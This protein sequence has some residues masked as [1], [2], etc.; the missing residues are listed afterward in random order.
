MHAKCLTQPL[1][2]SKAG[3]METVRGII[4]GKFWGWPCGLANMP[5]EGCY[6]LSHRKPRTLSPGAPQALSQ[7]VMPTIPKPCCV[8]SNGK[9]IPLIPGSPSVNKGEPTGHR[10]L[11][12]ISG[13]LMVAAPSALTGGLAGL[14]H[15]V[16]VAQCLGHLTLLG[17]VLVHHS[18]LDSCQ[19]TVSGPQ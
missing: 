5:P 2:R 19:P 9:N 11:S 1:A 6:L 14:S 4:S 15:P 7:Q 18:F 8:V 12:H 10:L 13:P 3:G 17:A 16:A